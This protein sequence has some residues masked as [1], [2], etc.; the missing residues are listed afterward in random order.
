[1]ARAKKKVTPARAY[2]PIT[3]RTS[4]QSDATLIRFLSDELRTTCG[5][6]PEGVRL[7]VRT[8]ASDGGLH[9]ALD[10]LIVR[11]RDRGPR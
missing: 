5:L 6:G 3:Q 1:M 4:E 2:D 10:E 8:I 9:E 7:L 11:M